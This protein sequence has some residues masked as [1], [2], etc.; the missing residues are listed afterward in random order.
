MRVV[1]SAGGTGGHIYPALAIINKIKE[2]E[3]DSEFLYIGTHNRM[4]KDIIP[5]KGIPYKEIEI[6]G[7]N[8]KALSNFKLLKCIIKSYKECK[9]AI[10]SFKPD[11]VIGVGGYVTA[12]VILAASKLKY[13]TFIHE[14]NSVPGK[15]NKF[16]SKYVTK[17][18]ISFEDTK[19]YFD[20]NKTV[21]TGNPCNEA[22]LSS[23]KMDLKEVGLTK[24]FVYIVMGSLGSDKMS[25]IL[26][27]MLDKFD[28][29]DYEVVLVTGTNYFDKVK[30]LK[31][32]KNIKV[33][34]YVDNQTRLMKQAKLVVSRCGATTLGE[35][36]TLGLPSIIIPS[37]YV[38]D[39]HQYKNGLVLEEKEAAVMI[40]EK[41]LTSDYLYEQIDKLM[42]DSEKLNQMRE[43]L[44]GLTLA[45]GATNIYDVLTSMIGEKNG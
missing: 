20:E 14:Q 23:P 40:E 8:K 44:N 33:L 31:F 38:A 16:L 12:P 6:Y 30:D 27:D 34:P 7:F 45:D 29:K 21:F 3:P 41:D 11:I 15:T 32:P 22:A 13:K 18:G 42:N 35:I 25:N 17:I 19:K 9:K 4:E 26:I 37:P 28:K 36:A 1:I 2:K 39:N 43:N 10:K 5:K 24:D